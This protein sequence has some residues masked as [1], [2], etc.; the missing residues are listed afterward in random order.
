MALSSGY[1]LFKYMSWCVYVEG[2]FF[3]QTTTPWFHGLGKFERISRFNS[4]EGAYL[5]RV[6]E[7]ASKVEIPAVLVAHTEEMAQL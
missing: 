5:Y 4:Q 6:G 3:I 2:D 1:Q 7:E